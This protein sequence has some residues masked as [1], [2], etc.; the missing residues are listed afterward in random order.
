MLFFTVTHRDKINAKIYAP[1]IAAPKTD[2][3][4]ALRRNGTQFVAFAVKVQKIFFS[5]FEVAHTSYNICLMIMIQIFTASL[6]H[7]T[8]GC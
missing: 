3:Y 4:P 7:Q 5:C 1:N 6:F 8:K 2:P